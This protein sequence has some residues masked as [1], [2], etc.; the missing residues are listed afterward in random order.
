MSKRLLSKN[1]VINIILQVTTICSGLIIP[2]LII[3]TYGSNVNGLISSITQFLSY[4]ALLEGGIGGVIKAV[5]Y[6]PLLNKDRAA[7]VYLRCP[8]SHAVAQHH[9]LCNND[10]TWLQSGNRQVSNG[11]DFYITPFM[12]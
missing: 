9:F 2:R 4:I 8:N 5:L 3:K 12:L 11:S 7:L 1:I 6:K 10:S